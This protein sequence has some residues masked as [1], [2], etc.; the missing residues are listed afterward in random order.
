MG[1]RWV[2]LTAVA[3]VALALLIILWPRGS[4]E[5]QILAVLTEIA[6]AV[7]RKDVGGCMRH[8]SQ[9]YRDSRG[10]TK[11]ELVRQAWAGFRETGDLSVRVY[12]P[13]V[14]VQGG[15]ATVQLEVLVEEWKREARAH[16]I[17]TPVTV[18]LRK[19]RWRWRVVG[20]EGWQA[21]RDELEQS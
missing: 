15:Q 14:M 21:A 6:Q 2:A 7:E 17:R 19:E 9:D 10:N 12:G 11:T 18:K 20:A 4:P 3:C 16:S 5:E 1:R 13:Q 8:V